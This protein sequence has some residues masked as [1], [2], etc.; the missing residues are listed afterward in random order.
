MNVRKGP[1]IYVKNPFKMFYAWITRYRID[2]TISEVPIEMISSPNVTSNTSELGNETGV[3]N[4]RG[5]ATSLPDGP[6]SKKAM[7]ESK[8]L[9]ENIKQ[10]SQFRYGRHLDDVEEMIIE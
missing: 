9:S 1:D 2:N 7:F 3:I 4:L 8:R 10:H 6:K 5:P